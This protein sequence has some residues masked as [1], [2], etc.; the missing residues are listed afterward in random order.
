VYELKFTERHDYASRT[1]GVF[2]PVVLISGSESIELSAS[3]DTGATFCLFSSE[4]ARALNINIETGEN[5]TF[6]T[7]NSKFEAYGHLL[8]IRVLGI[9]VEALATFRRKND[10]QRDRVLQEGVLRQ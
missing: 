7:A 3:I 2:V 6:W 5:R 9:N 10:D 8:T 1:E 4:Y